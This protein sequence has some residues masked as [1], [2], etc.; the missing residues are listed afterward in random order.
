MQTV[1]ILPV[2]GARPCL[3]KISKYFLPPAQLYGEDDPVTWT[4]H[5]GISRGTPSLWCPSSVFQELLLKFSFFWALSG[6]G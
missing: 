2:E 3:E 1:P 4:P 6:L 5:T